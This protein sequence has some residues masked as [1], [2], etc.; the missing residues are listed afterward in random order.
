MGGDPRVM[1]AGSAREAGEEGAGDRISKG[2]GA[3][4]NRKKKLLNIAQFFATE[5]AHSGG[6]H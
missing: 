4:R 6:N 5:N 1:R 2:V 3:G